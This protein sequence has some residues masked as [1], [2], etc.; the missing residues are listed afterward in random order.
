MH[1][2]TSAHNRIQELLKGKD[3]FMNLSRNLAQK[4]QARERTTIQP[5]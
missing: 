3:N 5:K 4:A 1:S 2:F